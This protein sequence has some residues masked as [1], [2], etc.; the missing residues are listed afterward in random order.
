MKAKVL[1]R[2][3]AL[4]MSVL[5]ML[6]ASVSAFATDVPSDVLTKLVE[7]SDFS[8]NAT[9]PTRRNTDDTGLCPAHGALTLYTTLDAYSGNAKKTLYITVFVTSLDVQPDV[10]IDVTVYKPDGGTL[11][12]FKANPTVEEYYLDFSQPASGT[13][14]VVFESTVNYDIYCT[15]TWAG[16]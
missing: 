7:T 13:Y 9:V 16:W 8:S 12:R 11:I 14:T 5:L 1:K 15:A 2:F 6:G 10:E 4:V 3:I